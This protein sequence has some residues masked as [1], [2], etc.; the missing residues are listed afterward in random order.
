ME[1]AAHVH[2]NTK[3]VHRLTLQKQKRQESPGVMSILEAT[4]RRLASSTADVPDDAAVTRA[5]FQS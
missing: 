3:R 5:A 2:R 4:A 1:P